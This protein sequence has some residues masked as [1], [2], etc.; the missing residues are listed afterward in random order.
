MARPKT[1]FE[2]AGVEPAMAPLET[3]AV[4]LID[5]QMEY[6]DGMLALP[7]AAHALTEA[8]RLV[9]WARGAGRPVIHIQHKGRAGGLF[10]PAGPGFAIAPAVAPRP[11][12]AWLLKGL[13]NSFAGTELE[14]E[15]RR[16]KVEQVIFAGFM[17]HM[18]VSSTVR[19]ALDRGIGAAVLASACATRDLA[20]PEGAV[21]PAAALH[22]AELAALADRFALIVPDVD[23]L[24]KIHA[25]PRA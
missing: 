25:Q 12:E 4:V 21:V 2:M 17:T 18:C 22:R 5:M 23:G 19:A 24:L 1:L 8:A 3:I 14:A 16:R 13:P 6:V 10:D 20:D 7:G 11:G 15:I 9:E